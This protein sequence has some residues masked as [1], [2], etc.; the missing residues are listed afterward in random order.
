MI[1][2][3]DPNRP[4][5]EREL[6]QLYL[7]FAQPNNLAM[8]QCMVIGLSLNNSNTADGWAGAGWQLATMLICVAAASRV[9]LTS[10]VDKQ[11]GF[12][13]SGGSGISVIW[14]ILKKATMV[15]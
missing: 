9:V 12:A 15:G 5:Q 10:A 8:K 13:E 2:L 1:L 6:E 3:I 4:E 11:A 7:N 14:C